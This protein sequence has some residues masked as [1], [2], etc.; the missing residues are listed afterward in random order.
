MK[1]TTAKKICAEL[2][3]KYM[4]IK[5][6]TTAIT[7]MERTAGEDT[8]DYVYFTAGNRHYVYNGRIYESFVMFPDDTLTDGIQ[9]EEEIRKIEKKH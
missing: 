2:F 3:N 8:I 5:I 9:L 1:K 4:G 6:P 7:L